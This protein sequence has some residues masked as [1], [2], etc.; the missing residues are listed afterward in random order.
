M[1]AE[2]N[3]KRSRRRRSAEQKTQIVE[4]ETEAVDVEADEEGD[5]EATTGALQR[6][7]TA[8]KGRVTVGRR[9]RQQVEEPEGNIATRSASGLQEYIAGVR[10]ELRKVSWPTREEAIRLMRIVIIVT[11]IASVVL[12]LISFAF[13]LLFQQGLQN[14]LVFV[15][16]FVVITP[17]AY[18]AYRA[19]TNSS[20]SD[21][22]NYPTRL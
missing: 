9:N 19:Y 15:A 11:A 4:T 1:S 22:S 3:E 8:P 17:I 16:F 21:S 10:D 18:L 20:S 6:G 13:T 14:P 12:G 7:Y 2:I 5:A